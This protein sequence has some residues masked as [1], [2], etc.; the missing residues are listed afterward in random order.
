MT[1]SIEEAKK[2]AKEYEGIDIHGKKIRIAF[3]YEGSRRFET[4]KATP[5]T[6]ANIKSAWKKR[7]RIEDE[8]ENLRN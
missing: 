3:K 4:L 2:V 7:I 8:I 1:L 6:K 5:L